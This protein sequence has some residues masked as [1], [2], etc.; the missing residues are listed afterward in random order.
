MVRQTIREKI[1]F[2]LSLTRWVEILNR[3]EEKTAQT[4]GYSQPLHGDNWL[5]VWFG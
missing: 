4:A 3:V 1:G 2:K 5:E